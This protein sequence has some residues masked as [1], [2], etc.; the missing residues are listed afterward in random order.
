M[1]K[2]NR[3]FFHTVVIL[4]VFF[5]M[6][7][8]LL[9]ASADSK[10]PFSVLVMVETGENVVDWEKKIF[11]HLERKASLEDQEE[12]EEDIQREKETAVTEKTSDENLKEDIEATV[13]EMD[14]ES[15]E[16]TDV[17]SEETKALSLK[18]EVKIEM[19]E[20]GSDERNAKWGEY[21]GPTLRHERLEENIE[22]VRPAVDDHEEQIVYKDEGSMFPLD[23]IVYG[24]GGS[25]YTPMIN[26]GI[27]VSYWNLFS[28]VSVGTD[29]SSSL[30]RPI[31]VNMFVGGFYRLWDISVNAALGYEKIWDFSDEGTLD[32]YSLGF[33]TGLNYHML[34]WMSISAGAGL[35][36]CIMKDS[37]FADGKFVPMIFGGFEFNLIK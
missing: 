10:D 5:L 37:G 33:K 21:Y 1:I 20:S 11:T 23:I 3:I 26:T 35:N 19:D 30:N 9:S 24:Q 17:I 34:S 4:P 7:T 28:S 16:H 32:N 13:T 6:T 27:K 15:L 8:R 29:F 18:D 22:T 36:Y 14:I 31:G 2:F 25:N 12:Q